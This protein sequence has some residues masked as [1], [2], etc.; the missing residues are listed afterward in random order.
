MSLYAYKLTH[1]TGFAPNPFWG[2]LTLATCKPKMRLKRD[3]GDWIAGFT[4][5]GLCRDR[6]GDERLI[7]LMHVEEKLRIA[8]YFEDERF[9]D[10]IPNPDSDQAV[11]RAGDNI[12]RPLRPDAIAPSD[13]EQLRNPNHW[14]GSSNCG[15]GDARKTDV[16][17]QYVL[18][19]RRFVYFGRNALHIPGDV[20]PAV[21][22]N[23][24]AYGAPTR[25]ED[26]IRSFVEYVFEQA[27]GKQVI[28][29]PHD[30]PDDDDSW[31]D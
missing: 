9:A 11:Q 25:H 24:S 2:V 8:E 19:G 21:P 5:S 29:P 18:I 3:K 7:Y 14:D 20:R 4:S 6:P 28:A 26:R 12:Y 22:T 27:D 10:K 23:M 31:I 17:G 15:V 16:N 30:W 1:D 13:F